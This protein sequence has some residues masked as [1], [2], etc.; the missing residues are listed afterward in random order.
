MKTSAGT[1]RTTA[2]LLIALLIS[3]GL[4]ACGGGGSS[5]P[6]TSGPA[7]S[8][9]IASATGYPAGTTFA[10]STASPATEAPPGNSPEFTN[11]FVSVKKI[12]L[13]PS[14]GAEFPDAGGEMES[15]S[16]NEGNGFVTATFT[17][18]KIDLLNLNSSTGDNVATL[19][20]KFP[21]VPAGEY[22]KIRVY[23]DNVV[24]VK[25]DNTVS[26]FHQT[27]NYHFDVHFVGGNLVIPVTTEI[28]EQGGIRFY[29]VLI[30]V[31]GL[32]YHQAGQSGNILMRPQV[33]A[34]VTSAPEYI[35]SGV[36]QNV[37]PA[38]NTFDIDTG[39]TI[40][41]AVYGSTTTWIYVDNTVNPVRKS[42]AAGAFLG[43]SGLDNGAYVEAIGTFT[44][45]NV[46]LAR[47]VDVTLRAAISG[48]VYLGWNNA[49]NTITLRFAGDNVV[50]VPNGLRN[51]VFYDNAVSPFTQL[52]DSAIT[53]NVFITARGY[54]TGS[55]VKAYWISIG[56]PV[57]GP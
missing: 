56:E 14:T 32:K 17:P 54:P 5:S 42:S 11:V 13:I 4:A 41:T 28:H 44:S 25:A 52:N 21:S 57:V 3:G 35:V 50:S 49:D 6:G 39:G 45:D 10:T 43:A 47:E 7:V 29:S 12:A 27:G 8:V 24:G 34:T 16:S 38:D 1:L 40:V 15:N 19:L 22:S 36:A 26:Q 9:S 53:D 51:T 30:N 23:Y 33:F 37:N 48:K 31:V 18:V 55:G 46:L 2:Y 20:N